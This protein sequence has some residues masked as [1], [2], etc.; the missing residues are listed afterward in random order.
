MVAKKS[1]IFFFFFFFSVYNE[2]PKISWESFD[3][4]KH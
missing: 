2:A 1:V 4:V 3:F